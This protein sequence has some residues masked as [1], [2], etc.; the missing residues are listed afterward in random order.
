MRVALDRLRQWQQ[1]RRLKQ[2][3][4][5]DAARRAA[6]GASWLDEADPG[7]AGRV[8]PDM[9]ALADGRCCVLGQLHGGFRQG[10]GRSSLWQL[11]SAPRANLSPVSYGFLCVQDVPAEAQARDYD[12]LT[13][14]WE[15]EIAR[16]HQPVKRP[17][18]MPSVQEAREVAAPELVA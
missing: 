3:T 7:W 17:V 11:G 15:A 10:L 8:D 13:A 18:L 2:I 4:P 5:A 14:A 12:L 9:L 16:R 6:R 1:A